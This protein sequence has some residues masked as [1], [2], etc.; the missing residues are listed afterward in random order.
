MSN[1]HIGFGAI[2]DRQKALGSK[3]AFS[4]PMRQVSFSEFEERVTRLVDGLHK[5]G[6]RPGDR[7]AVLSKN[8][9]NAAEC[10][11]ACRAGFIIVPLNWRLS[12][13]ELVT[14][15]S[16]CSPEVLICDMQWSEVADCEILPHLQAM[17]LVVFGPAQSGWQAYE[18]VV[19]SGNEGAYHRDASDRATAL[20][21]Y[22]SGTT[23]APKAAMI[24]HAGLLGNGLAAG[25]EALGVTAEDK[26]LCVLPMFHVGGLCYY[27]IPSY[28]AG[29]TCVLRPTFQVDDLVNSLETF[30]ITNVHLVPTMIADLV[31]HP[32]AREAAA[33]LRRIVYAGSTMPVALLERA[34]N[35]LESC[36][37]S[38]SYGSTE[39]GIITTLSPEDHRAAATSPSR[40][41]LLQSCGR[42]LSGTQ[43]RM[44]DDSGE[45]CAPGETGEVLVLSERSMVGYWNQPEKSAGLRVGMFMRTGDIGYRDADGYVYLVDRKGDMIVTGGE[46]V[47]P[48]EVEQVL[49][50]CP[51]VAEASVFGV[52]DARWIEKVVAAVILKP[53]S[54]ATP[55]SISQFVREHLAPYKCPKEVHIVRDLPR[56]GVGKVSRRSLR[57]MYATSKRSDGARA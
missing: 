35:V 25:S 47:F 9:V 46:N 49:Y 54:T 53:G 12:P 31:G 11:A 5:L 50:R 55:G 52:P 37:F 48:S 27:L 42:P 51:D 34:M 16:D 20:L 28:M 22:T 2:V 26:I 13:P 36:E 17:K 32:R 29:A 18:D 24:T 43:L 30:T 19:S 15:L 3:V 7:V 4:D 56:T 33:Q 40:A 57:E 14:L 1:R 39:G 44:V 6:I 23:G 10:I 45:D 21:I 38:Q 41:H 8:S